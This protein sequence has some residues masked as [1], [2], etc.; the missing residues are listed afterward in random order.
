M[1][2][3]EKSDKQPTLIRINVFQSSMTLGSKLGAY[4][5][6]TYAILFLSLYFD[7]MS[8]LA[9]PAMVGIPFVAYFLLKKFRDSESPEFYPFPVS[10]MMSILTF[11]FA[12][13]LSCMAVF[14]F[15]K[16]FKPAG[17]E[18][19]MLSHIDQFT[20]VMQQAATG[21]TDQSRI[22]AMNG[23]I[24]S[25]VKTLK[26]ICSLSASAFTKMLVQSSLT[27]GNIF[28]LIIGIIVAKRIKFKQS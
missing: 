21:Q 19:V 24:D 20:A 6:L 12:G 26:W 4:M 16:F 7:F 5:I 14:V 23:Q 8:L 1:P 10:W 27:W 17:L 13:V 18:Q 9:L 25:M 3:Q 22:D 28:S 11:L 2:E 15:L